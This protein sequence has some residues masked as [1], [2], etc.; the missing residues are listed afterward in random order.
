MQNTRFLQTSFW[1]QFKGAHGWNPISI[2]ENGVPL[3]VLVRTFRIGFKKASIAYVPMAPE[4]DGKAG[5]AYIKELN[6][7]AL[8]L[9]SSIP[10]DTMCVRFDPP[11]DFL[12]TE[13]R[14]AFDKSLPAY[15]KETSSSVTKSP[16]AVQ[17]PD[18]VLLSLDKS[19]EDLLNNMKPKWRY[20]VKLAEKKG[21]TVTAYHA[22]DAGFEEAFDSFYELFETTGKRDGISPH[23]KSYYKDLLTRGSPAAQC[24]SAAAQEKSPVVTL[25]L[26]SHENDKLAG[27]ITLFCDREAVYLYGASGNIKRNLMP[28]YLLQWTAICDARQY[29]CPVYDFYG[30]PP[31]DDPSHPMHVLYLFKTGFGGTIVHRPGS[32]DVPLSGFYKWYIAAEKARAWYHR[33]FL[34]KIRGR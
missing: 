3:S 34:K 11:V 10:H 14:D 9:R 1:A 12:T 19:K 31:T 13:E 2:T 15:A 23:A 5:A 33:S 32:F 21:V 16:V 7:I 17:P 24:A 4:H 20:N 27:I 29:G 8:S 25:Y 26:A 30:M 28:A 18:T 22:G 6:D